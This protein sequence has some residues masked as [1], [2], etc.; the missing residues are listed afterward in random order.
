MSNIPEFI[1]RP[2]EFLEAWTCSRCQE[3]ITGDRLI[4]TDLLVFDLACGR[5]VADKLGVTIE[6]DTRA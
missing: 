5:L 1:E 2:V 3:D 6:D 4:E